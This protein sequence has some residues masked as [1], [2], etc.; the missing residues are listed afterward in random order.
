MNQNVQ[1]NEN[2]KS[3]DPRSSTNPRQ[4][5]IRKITPENITI[6]LSKTSHVKI[7]S[8]KWTDRR[9]VK[10]RKTKISITGIKNL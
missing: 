7:K 2:Y 6:K 4:D 1:I 8:L 5:K 9:H 3:T 10:Y